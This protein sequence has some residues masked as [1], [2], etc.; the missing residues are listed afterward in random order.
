[1]STAYHPQIDGQSERTIQ[2]L[3]DMLRA[4]V[5][6]FGESWDVHLPLV[7]FSYNNNYHSSIRCAPFEALHA[8]RCRSPILRAEIREGQLIGPEI[9][10]PQ[11][12]DC[13]EV[14]GGPHYS[15]NCQA[16][17][18]PIYDQ[19][20]CYNQNFNDDQPPFYSS[21]QQQFN[22][23]EVCGGPHCRSDCQIR[24]PLVYEPNPSN[25]YD[26]PCFDQP[27]QYH[28]D[29][30]PPQD[31]VFDSLMHSYRENICILGEIRRTLEAN[32]P[33]DVKEPEGSD[34]YTEVTYDKEQCLSD[35][36]TAPVTPLA[37]T[38]SITIS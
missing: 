26:F 3:K 38:P 36:Y 23:C 12:F 15:S 18:T 8:I 35:H 29:Q 4:C 13:C 30:S 25:N 10:L 27:P 5:L 20:P 24:N 19:G 9:V 6:D 21:N 16:G 14:C 17:N 31:L 37:Y 11:Q 34:D 2:T 32:S 33:V 1:M 22:C 28:I 7:E